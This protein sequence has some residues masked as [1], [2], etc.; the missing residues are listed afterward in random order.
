[1][2]Q[3]QPRAQSGRSGC[4][5][6][7]AATHLVT[8]MTRVDE[9]GRQDACQD[10][11]PGPGRSRPRRREASCSSTILRVRVRAGEAQRCVISWASV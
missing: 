1:M 10:A 5:T 7:E 6:C 4:P 9:F 3:G 11:A 8:T 2:A